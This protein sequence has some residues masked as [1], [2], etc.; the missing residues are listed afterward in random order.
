MVTGLWII[1]SKAMDNRTAIDLAGGV[2]YAFPEMESKSCWHKYRAI[3]KNCSWELAS[4]WAL[5]G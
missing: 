2:W 4:K 3:A 1:A 5:P